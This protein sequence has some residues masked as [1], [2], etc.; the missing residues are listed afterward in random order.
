MAILLFGKVSSSNYVC[1][2]EKLVGSDFATSHIPRTVAASVK[3]DP[4]T[5]NRRL[6]TRKK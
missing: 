3:D 6:N 4:T 2:N 5:T 1:T